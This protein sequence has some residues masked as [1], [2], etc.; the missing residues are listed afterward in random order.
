MLKQL[1]DYIVTS[2]QTVEI[3]KCLMFN[4]VQTC[5]AWYNKQNKSLLKRSANGEFTLIKFGYT[6]FIQDTSYYVY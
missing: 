6:I 3:P 1:L 2:M 4:V 5:D